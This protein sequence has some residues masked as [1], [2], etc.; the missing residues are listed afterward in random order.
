MPQPA[1]LLNTI[2]LVRGQTKVFHVTVKTCEGRAASLSGATLYFT[3]RESADSAALIALTSPD[4]GIEITDAAE[5]KATV[6]ISSTDSDIAKGCYGFDL[7]VELP[8]SPPVRHPVVKRSE[9]IVEETF[10]TFS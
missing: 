2:R 9:F 6:T 8:G 4:D 1:N 10:T 7:W 3:V 5:G